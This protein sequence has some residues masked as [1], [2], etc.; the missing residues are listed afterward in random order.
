MQNPHNHTINYFTAAPPPLSLRWGILT[1]VARCAG[2]HV[3]SMT[4]SVAGQDLEVGWV[5]DRG[6]QQDDA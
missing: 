6:H 2:E 5:H 4:V 3:A 1:L